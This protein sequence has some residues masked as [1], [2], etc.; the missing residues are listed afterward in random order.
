MVPIEML[1]RYRFFAGFD[2]EQVDDLARVASEKSVLKGHKFISEGDHL[3]KFYLLL[4]GKV[5]IT[6]K[7]PDQGIEQSLTRQITNTLITKDVVV[8]NV[9]AGEVF[10]WSAIIPPNVST[11]DA[12]ALSACRVLEFDYQALEPILAEDCHF[13]HMLTMKTAQIIRGRLRDKYIEILPE[14]VI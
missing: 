6:I 12:K 11:A 10:G 5:G 2:R 4:E 7:I 8:S 13:S 1:R 9:G 3:T 14:V